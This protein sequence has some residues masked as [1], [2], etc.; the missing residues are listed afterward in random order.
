MEKPKAEQKTT[1]RTGKYFIVGV[2]LAVFNFA[3][4]TIIARLI[5]NNDF[6][7]LATIISTFF[8]AV[9]AFILHSKITW[10]ERHPGKAGIVKFAIYNL[11]LTVAI[12]PFFT[13]LFYLITPLYEFAFNIS[14]TIHLPFDYDFVESA[15]VFVLVAA[16][17]MIINYLCYDKIVFKPNTK[18][19]SKS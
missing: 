15:G 4:Y 11:L 19:D 18:P 9:L 5:G 2:S 10:K 6:L 1:A 7:W 8:T 17:T 3:L 14:Q 16:T 12:G 13:W